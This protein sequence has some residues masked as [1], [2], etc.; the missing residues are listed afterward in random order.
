MQLLEI[1]NPVADQKG[2][3][4]EKDAVELYIR[5]NRGSIKCPA[6]GMYAHKPAHARYLACAYFCF[7]AC[8]T[9]DVLKACHHDCRNTICSSQ[10]D[11]PTLQP[12]ILLLCLFVKKRNEK[13]A[14]LGVM[15]RESAMLAPACVQWTFL[16]LKKKRE[17]S[18]V[19]HHLKS[20]N[21]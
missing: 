2:Y 13:C 10:V 11:W 16:I 7:N 14:A 12:V 4:Y 15:A 3:V 1:E 9:Y 21:E 5:Q 20:L 8:W 17:L 19:R 18:A 6:N